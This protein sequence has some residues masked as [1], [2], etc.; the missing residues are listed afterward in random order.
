MNALLSH[1]MTVQIEVLYRR[2]AP[3]RYELLVNPL[4]QNQL[5]VRMRDPQFGESTCSVAAWSNHES[6]S[7]VVRAVHA[8]VACF[9]GDVRA[10][11][12]IVGAPDWTQVSIGVAHARDDHKRKTSMRVELTLQSPTRA[13]VVRTIGPRSARD[14]AVRLC[15][16]DADAVYAITRVALCSSAARVLDEVEAPRRARIAVANK[17]AVAPLATAAV[18]PEWATLQR[19]LE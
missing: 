6:E 14:D 17:P 9:F 5:S 7:D 2:D 18:A 19:L 12:R 10:V 16:E 13:S 8:A 3:E 4:G 15:P 1:P 11:P